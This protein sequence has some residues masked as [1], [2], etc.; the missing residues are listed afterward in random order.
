[1]LKNIE[2]EISQID[3]SKTDTSSGIILPLETYLK[4]DFRGAKLAHVRRD[5]GG[6]ISRVTAVLESLQNPQRVTDEMNL[7]QGLQVATRVVD[8]VWETVNKK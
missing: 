8:T 5:V 3:N 1:M 4:D 7:L 2:Q 6:M